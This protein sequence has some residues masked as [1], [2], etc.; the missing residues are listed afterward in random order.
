MRPVLAVL[1]LAGAL[2]ALAVAT[3]IGFGWWHSESDFRGW[4]AG[5]VVLYVASEGIRA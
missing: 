2:V 1:L 3:G 4:I 5:G